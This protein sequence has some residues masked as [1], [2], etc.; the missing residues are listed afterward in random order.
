MAW[1]ETALNAAADGIAD[2]ATHASLHSGDP[3]AS[4]TNELSG[5]DPAYARQAVGWGAASNGE[6]QLDDDYTFN[7]PGGE[8]VA[9]VGYWT[10]PTG[11]TFLGSFALTPEGPYGAQGEYVLLASATKIDAANPD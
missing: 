11:G 3:G 9:Y 7:I 4:G 6:R 5:G 1:Q 2:Q 10:G 8:T